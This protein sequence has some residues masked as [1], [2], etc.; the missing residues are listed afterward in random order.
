MQ[1]KKENYFYFKNIKFSFKK[2]ELIGEGSY[3][4]VLLVR[5]NDNN[6]IYC[7]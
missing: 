2:G 5:K 6:K 1:S 3:G 4:K 7:K